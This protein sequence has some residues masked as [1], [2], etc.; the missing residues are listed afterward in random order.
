MDAIFVNIVGMSEGVEIPRWLIFQ[1]HGGEIGVYK[2]FIIGSVYRPYL[3][4]SQH[5]CFAHRAFAPVSQA[6]SN[7]DVPC[8]MNPTQ[9]LCLKAPRGDSFLFSST[10]PK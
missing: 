4:D 3:P 10:V 1:Y 5:D 6:S 2:G 7:C 9:R 8:P